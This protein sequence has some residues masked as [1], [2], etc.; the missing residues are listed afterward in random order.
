MAFPTLTQVARGLWKREGTLFVLSSPSGGGKTTVARHVIAQLSWV[1]RS[2]SV[3]TRPRRADERE[4]R[5]YHFVSRATFLRDRARRAYLEW[6]KVHEHFYATP[7][8]PVQQQLARGRDVVLVIDVQGA[9]QVKRRVPSSI[10]V[11][12]LP[13]SWAA[14][15]RR[16]R[17]RATEDAA[18]ISRRL[19]VARREVA[20][21]RQYDYVVVNDHL[22]QA[23]HEL[24]AI[25]TAERRRA[26]HRGQSRRE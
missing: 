10:S 6:A 20:S 12:L 19:R 11:F 26:D 14:L 24:A 21:A 5:D 23:V 4:G 13:P 22:S 3:T 7:W 8:R 9:A 18:T 16:L 1:T 25:I 2:I 15:A 17:Q